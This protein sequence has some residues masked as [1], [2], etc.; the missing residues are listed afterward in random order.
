MSTRP[1]GKQVHP[2]YVPSNFGPVAAPESLD[3][4]LAA[5]DA[6]L[7][8]GGGAGAGLDTFRFDSTNTYSA[9]Y[10]GAAPGTGY[11]MRMWNPAPFTAADLT[12]FCSQFGG[13]GNYQLGIY[14]A[15]GALLAATVAAPVASV[16]FK[17][18]ALAAPL[19]VPKGQCWLAIWSD[20]NGSNFPVQNGRVGFGEPNGIELNNVAALPANLAAYL[21]NVRS[22]RYFVSANP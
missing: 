3:N 19:S 17:T 11:A 5:I 22:L 6:A 21:G 15:A 2:E 14:N 20:S 7:G 1:T 10:S 12:T 9:L 8:G 4:Y 13:A 18:A 16:G